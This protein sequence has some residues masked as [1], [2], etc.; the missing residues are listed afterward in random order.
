MDTQQPYRSTLFRY[1]SKVSLILLII[2]MG[3]LMTSA[4]VVTFTETMGTVG[5]TT[6]LV[7]HEA[8]N[9]Y[10]N[11]S[12]TMT[13]GGAA[14]TADLR[15]T[16]VSSG[17]AGASGGA[18]VFFTGTGTLGFQIA[19]ISTV[20]LTG[21]TVQFG[22]R[23]ESATALPTLAFDYST[24]GVGYTSVAFTFTQIA[25]AATGW[26]LSPVITLPVG[27]ENAAN[28]RL[29]WIK[30]GTNSTRIDDVVLKNTPAGAS[31]TL[32]TAGIPSKFFTVASIASDVYS[33]TVTGSGLGSNNASVSAV[34]GFE[35]S[36]NVAGP[37]VA[38]P[39][40]LTPSAGSISAP[41]YVRVVAGAAGSVSGTCSVTSAVTTTQ[42]V[43][44]SGQKYALGSSFT[45]G[46]LVVMR[47]GE[48]GTTV[49]A[50]TAAPAFLDELTP[51]GAL[52]QTIPLPFVLN[53]LNRRMN[54]SSSSTSDG[55]L[56]LS[57]D[58]QYLTFVGYDAAVFTSGVTASAAA[59]T[60]R[61]VGLVS[62]NGLINSTTRIND[63]YDA[64]NARSAVTLDG[65][66][67]W[68]SGAG[69]GGGTRYVTL[70]NTGTSTYVSTTPANTRVVN[71]SNN[72]LYV[73]SASGANIGLNQVAASG[74]PTSTGNTTTLLI[75]GIA[76][77]YGFV[78]LDRDAGIAGNDVVYIANNSGGLLKYYF[79]GSAWVAA[80]SVAST[81][82]VGIT[83]KIVGANVEIYC[84]GN[85]AATIYKIVD[86]GAY[87]ATLSGSL[88]SF[89]T[90]SVGTSLRGVSFTPVA[91]PVPT[92]DHTFST[93]APATLA[94]GVADAPIY[95]VEL[96]ITTGAATITGAT[97][98]TAGSYAA[99]DIS[100]FKLYSST[101]AVLDG[102]DI[103]LST[104]STST[105]PGQS[106]AFTGLG[107]ILPIGTRYLFV[108]ASVSGCANIGN[109]INITSTP[110]SAITY[111]L[112]TKTGTPVAG[113]SK[114]V[115]A[116]TLANVTALNATS[117]TP[118]V[119]VSWTNPSCFDQ[120]LIV[121]H[122]ASISGVPSGTVYSSNLNYTLAP[123]FTGGGKIVYYGTTSPQTISGLTSG[124]NYFIK[125][126]VRK[127]T[128][129]SSGV[130]VNATPLNPTLYSVGTG[131]AATDAIW[132][133][134]PAG[135]GATAASLGGFQL[136]TSV[137][138]QTGTTVTFSTSNVNMFNLTVDNGGAM[139]SGGTSNTYMNINGTSLTNNGTI[140]TILNDGISF[141]IEGTQ[142]VWSGTGVNNVARIRKNATTI[143]TSTLVFN[144]NVNVTFAGQAIYNNTNN[145]GFNVTVN[146][147]KTVNLT[148]TG[149]ILGDFAFDGTDG[150]NVN[151]RGGV[152]IVN[153][154][155]TMTGKLIATTNNTNA[156]FAPSVTIN[157][158]GKINCKDVDISIASAGTGFPFTINAGGRLNVS[159]KMRMISGTLNSN[160]G[161]FLSSGA[162]LL[163]GTGTLDG[164]VACNGSINGA[165]SIRRQGTVSP[166]KYNYWSSP[167]INSPNAV[168]MT[169][170]TGNN[171][172]EYVPANTTGSDIEGLR[173]GWALRSPS[174]IMDQGKGYIA[175][176]AGNANFMGLPYEGTLSLS[177]Q[178][179]AF[180]KFNLVGNPYPSSLSA[181]ALLSGNAGQ[182]VPA[183]YFWDDDGTAGASYAT[184]DYV[185]VNSLGAASGGNGSAASFTGQIASGQGFFV[186]AVGTSNSITFNNTMRSGNTANFFEENETLQ[187]V[188]I[189][190][191]N[192]NGVSNETMLAFLP[193]ASEGYDLNY[194]AKKLPGNESIS[195]YTSIADQAFAIQ[196]WPTLTDERIIPLGLTATTQGLH[197]FSIS[198]IDN[199]DPTVIVYLE[200]TQT[201]LFHNLSKS[202]YTFGMNEELVNS[203]RFRI[204]FSKATTVSATSTSCSGNDGS[205]SLTS[206][207]NL[208][209]YS[210]VSDQNQVVATGTTNETNT[211]SNLAAGVYSVVLTS[212]D[213]YE[214]VLF[215]E[216]Q[217]LN[218]ITCQVSSPESAN[219]N[220]ELSFISNTTGADL[221][222]WNFGDASAEVTGLTA[223]HTFTAPGIY[224]V[225]ITASNSVCSQTV[226]QTIQILDL[227]TGINQ[228][229][230]LNT[231]IFPNPANDQITLV[232]DGNKESVFEI[233]DLTGKLVSSHQLN[234]VTNQIQVSNLDGG[235]YLGT[236]RQNGSVKTFRLV[237]AH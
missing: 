173:A 152:L 71:I 10:D 148:A 109:T 110:L 86:S 25:T 85:A 53:G 191:N 60:N 163:H 202:E 159:G 24:D 153:G 165:I 195:L 104:I 218:T 3:N 139:T 129:W 206:Q 84:V 170:V 32:N 14:G 2:L 217:G 168:I 154:T 77:A 230:D 178:N 200:D 44:L 115:I 121:A 75:P 149:G 73:S 174:Q 161:I 145:T 18:N 23:K 130:Q 135:V 196:A 4:Q 87:N 119:Q 47:V 203:N 190:V 105:G 113:T 166:A 81:S 164:A 225:T 146:A 8:A 63:G 27:A 39:L 54:V 157:A 99:A 49:P 58:G 21:L 66:S 116:G 158:G 128:S 151:E 184:G 95:S 199:I 55:V 220:E 179:N 102:S 136:T 229:N 171:S 211:I 31:L 223:N 9:G 19:D 137:R 219:T 5:G 215:T 33:F 132:S 131:V 7:A 83:A 91:L 197:S 118:V 37:F 42:T 112:G 141:N 234:T 76:D 227:A 172:Y 111:T 57:P 186:E 124:T 176:N 123:A 108:T 79:N 45:P 74:L 82:I 13:N 233:H 88:T 50:S 96:D 22:Y 224:T 40:T 35:F 207:D 20:G 194:D 228:L 61:I 64:N 140:G 34:S 70:G 177:L 144:S 17:Y 138:I 160:N 52:V 29:R 122:T 147:G 210:I 208:W 46:N 162:V 30:S 62:S 97:F 12:Y 156:L 167:V 68:T 43:A 117:G 169:S 231:R 213:Q 216:V 235:I 237:V 221:I 26:Y 48:A 11:D 226:Q 28:L 15:A 65:T 232:I 51:A 212:N 114:S 155:L 209:N 101:N 106:L 182:V 205:I 142:V 150:A 201:G 181:T 94:Q 143:T 183:L 93:P 6:T 59:T 126:F 80:G 67:F 189:K 198:R 127:G 134:T 78:F 92:I 107:Q 175:T 56:N 222:T 38:G 133:L 98:T 180:T 204:H 193:S 185:A 103:V 16:N 187:R 236:I 69:T 41:I 125:V 192:P 188:W 214:V 89:Y 100:N 36:T 120:F 72:N 90:A 1:L